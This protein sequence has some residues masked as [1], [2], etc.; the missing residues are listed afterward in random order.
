MRIVIPLFDR[1]MATDAV[2]P[3]DVLSRLPGAETVFVA[4]RPGPVRDTS[5]SLALVADAA[6]DE[7]TEADILVVPGGQG[8]ADVPLD[9]A[10]HAWLRAVDA[11]TT[12]TATVCT[13]A[14]LLAA[15]GPLKGR[16]ATTHW[17]ALDRLRDLGVEPVEERHVIDGK[18][19]SAAGVSAGMDMAYVLA[20]LVAG[21]TVAQEIQLGHEYDPRPPYDAGS[22]ATAPPELVAAVRAASRFAP[23]AE[24][25]RG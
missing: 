2:G 15:A 1:F 4:E 16:R 5:G 13:G 23:R 22:P 10:L 24:P 12:W 20:G 8:E 21:D 18:Y 19:I 3:Y 14:L 25:L 17:L 11:T 6:L 9:G 7:V